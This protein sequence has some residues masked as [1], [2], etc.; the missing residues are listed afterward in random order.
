MLEKSD[1]IAALGQMKLLAPAR[2]K[3]ALAANDRLK[4]VLTVI[5]SAAAHA[6]ESSAVP[7][8]LRRDYAAARMDA[9]WLLDLAASAWREDSQLHL[10][11]LPRLCALLRDDINLMSRPLEGS[12]DP[13]HNSLLARTASWGDWLSRRD[14]TVLSEQELALLTGG[15]RGGEDTFHILVM[16]LHKALNRL[17][18]DVASDEIDGAHVWQMDPTDHPRVAAFMRGLNRTRGLKFDHPGL[19]TAA[20]RDGARLLIQND[21]GTNDAHVLVIQ[22]E[23]QVITLTYSDLHDRRFAFFQK[24]LEAIGASWS[25]VGARNTAGLNAGADYII[26]TAQFTCADETALLAALEA[27][28]ARIVFLIDW[29]RARKRLNLLVKKSISVSV[30]TETAQRAVGHMGWLLAGGERVIF[31]AMEALGPDYFRMGDQLDTVMGTDQAREFL[32]EAMSLATAGLQAK[33]ALTQIEDQTRLLLSRHMARHRD[34]FAALEEHAAFCHALAEGLR[35]AL[36]H[37]QERDAAAARKLAERAKGWERKADQ[38]VIRLREEAARNP[39]RQ[40]FLQV[41]EKADDAADALEEA[42]FLFSLI[43]E[44]RHKGWTAEIRAAFL[45]LAGQVL[46]AMQDHVRALAIARTLGE[47]STADDHD[48]FLSTCWRVVH[49]ERASDA[50]TRDLR[51]LLVNQ[52][53]DAATLQLATDLGA[54]LEESTDALLRTGYALRALI[55]TRIGT[56]LQGGG[57]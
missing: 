51:R 29:N 50:L 8:D 24:L 3:A 47:D 55:L 6:A 30:L 41:I 31:A 37:G 22:I 57:R 33:Q 28:G 40:P 23:G 21:I 14:A 48:A 42:A 44:G 39:H 26:G 35:D 32:I 17:A 1:A 12:D 5:Q 49:A 4:F 20:T 18:A 46:D 16:D 11:D 52:I 25:G 19:E 7:L 36:A 9:P 2:I 34:E 43:G 56:N 27:L 53:E 38:M 13:D 54:S 45:R 15:K 10:T